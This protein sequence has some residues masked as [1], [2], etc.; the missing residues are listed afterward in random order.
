MS[1][2]KAIFSAG[3]RIDEARRKTL[4]QLAATA[5]LSVLPLS[6]CSTSPSRENHHDS[7]LEI[8]HFLTG[9][10]LDSSYLQLSYDIWYL[11][12][13]DA[14]FHQR[15]LSLYDAYQQHKDA[16][17]IDSTQ[18]PLVQKILNAWYLS[19]V[20]LQY[21]DLTNPR[22]LHICGNLRQENLTQYHS[23]DIIIGQISYD[24]AL[25]WHACSFTKPSATC[26]GTFGYW[27]DKPTA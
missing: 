27:S 19:Q 12:S 10:E 23:G 16:M 3:T 18:Q 8:S 26:G 22:V 4:K 9:I 14:T 7:F 6:A 15:Y 17:Q 13:L 2:P 5:A 1:D 21:R 20:E 25:T 24:E 11:L